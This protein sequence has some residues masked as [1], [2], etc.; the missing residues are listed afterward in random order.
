MKTPRISS[1]T[2]RDGSMTLYV[3]GK[4]DMRGTALEVCVRIEELGVLSGTIGARL[5]STTSRLSAREQAA[6][7]M[8]DEILAKTSK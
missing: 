4:K 3:N 7:Q 5:A 2:N 8:A 1:T 6:A